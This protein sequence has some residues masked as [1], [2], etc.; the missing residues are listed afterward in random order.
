M[1]QS[2]AARLLRAGLI[3]GHLALLASAVVFGVLH[4]FYG[5]LWSVLSGLVTVL[6]FTIG[7]GIQVVVA[8]ADPK[9]VFAASMTSYVLRAA[10]LGLLLAAAQAANGRLVGLDPMAIAITAIAVVIG[11]LAVEIF[12]FTRLRIP[13]FDPPADPR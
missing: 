10:G 1:L 3:G 8:D 11:W 6:F 2:R 13:S 4:G 7:Q 5:A 12:V 9:V